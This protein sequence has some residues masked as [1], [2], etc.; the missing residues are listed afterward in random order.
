MDKRVVLEITRL[1]TEIAFLVSGTQIGGPP[2]E[3]E[4][5]E[6]RARLHTLLGEA[7][8]GAAR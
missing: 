2:H 6:L 4:L 5:A 3:Q 8:G 7:K 1:R